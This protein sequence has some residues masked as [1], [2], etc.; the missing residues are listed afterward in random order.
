MDEFE[1]EVIRIEGSDD[2]PEI[3][4]DAEN[5]IFKVSG[6]S[7]PENVIAVYSKILDW[8]ENYESEIKEN[9]LISEFYFKYI[10]TAS[11]KMVY[12]VLDKLE[13]IHADS[14]NITIIWGYNEKDEDMMEIGEEFA[15]L[16]EIP[17]DFAPVSN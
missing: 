10:N 8:L 3:F 6:I 9:G 11:Q 5:F 1:N 2:T 12:E 14:S 4:L 13:K 16:L 7:R 15:D 17:F